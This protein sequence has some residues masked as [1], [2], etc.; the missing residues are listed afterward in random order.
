MFTVMRTSSDPACASS[1]HCCAVDATSTVSVL[2]IDCTTTGAPPPTWIL[3]TFT[4]TVLCRFCVMTLLLYRIV[5]NI[6]NHR[7]VL[8]DVSVI[9]SSTRYNILP[10]PTVNRGID[11]RDE[12]Q[13][14]RDFQVLH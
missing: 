7:L 2:V 13:I 9:N 12:L 11:P 5:G 6:V 3:P 10:G 14:R 4:P 1:K 8:D